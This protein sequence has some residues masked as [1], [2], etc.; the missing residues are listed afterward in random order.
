MLIHHHMF[1]LFA[2][3]RTRELMNMR[4]AYLADWSAIHF[5]DI[6]ASPK[7]DRLATGIVYVVCHFLSFG[8]WPPLSLFELRTFT[9]G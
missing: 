6:T 1:L 4:S 9:F 7:S 2:D 5:V 3:I 8:R